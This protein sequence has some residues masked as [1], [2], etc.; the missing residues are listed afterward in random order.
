MAINPNIPTESLSL[1]TYEA[2]VAITA[3]TFVKPGTAGN[4]VTT[5]GAGE[6]PLG[7]AYSQ[8][9]AGELVSVQPLVPGVRMTVL[10]GAALAS[11]KTDVMS[12]AS[13][14][15]VA[16]TSSNQIAGQNR[17]TASGAD[18]LVQVTLEDGNRAAA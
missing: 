12:N 11:V 1:Q 17:T 10:S 4:Q 6:K 5:C 14:K 3:N 18:L 7:V 2:E 13:G 9:A 16:A 15:A 8:A